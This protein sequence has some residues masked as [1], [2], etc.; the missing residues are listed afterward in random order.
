MVRK[1]LENLGYVH[2]QEKKKLGNF[3]KFCVDCLENFQETY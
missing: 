1:N 2:F 3:Q